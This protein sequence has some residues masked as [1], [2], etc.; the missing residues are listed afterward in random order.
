MAS[1]YRSVALTASFLLCASTATAQ[2]ATDVAARK[3]D[4]S[5]RAALRRGES[6][7]RV[8]VTVKSGR[9]ADIRRALEAHGDVVGAESSLV[10]ALV[11]NIHTADIEELARRPWVEN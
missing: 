3:I 8:I 1:L 10:D 6:S 9:R 11:A 4:R 5:L 2:E 7:P